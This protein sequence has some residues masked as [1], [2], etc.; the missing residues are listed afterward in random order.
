MAMIMPARKAPKVNDRLIASVV[1]P[2]ATA[3]I[4]A[5]VAKTPSLRVRAMKPNRGRITRRASISA[6]T[7][8]PLAFRSTKPM[9]GATASERYAGSGL[10]ASG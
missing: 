9:A 7:K 3:T 4:S 10:D 5:T 2:A 1:H 6:T 8:A